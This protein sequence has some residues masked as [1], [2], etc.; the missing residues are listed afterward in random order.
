MSQV[1]PLSHPGV[2]AQTQGGTPLPLP[3]EQT[4]DALDTIE[5]AAVLE[6][7]AGHAVGTLGAARVRHRW[8]TDDVAWIRE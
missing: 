7:V 3:E 1:K 5:F 8:P 4:A 6:R 2:P